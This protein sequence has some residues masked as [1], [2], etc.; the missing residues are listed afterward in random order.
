MTHSAQFVWA[1]SPQFFWVYGPRTLLRLRAAPI[2]TLSVNQELLT[3]N[4]YFK[5]AGTVKIHK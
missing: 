5:A 1:F 2:G 4:V 3:K